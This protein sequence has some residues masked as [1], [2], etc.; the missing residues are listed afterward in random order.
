MCGMLTIDPGILLAQSGLM[1]IWNALW[2]YLL[3]FVG[4]SA[5]IFVHELG[6]FMVAKWMNVRVEK[7]AIGFFTELVGFTRGETRYSFNVLP[8]GG[9]VKMLGQ[10][11]FDDKTLELRTQGNPRS[12]VNKSVFQRMLIVSAGV[13]MNVLFAAFLFVIVFMHGVEENVTTIGQVLP[14]SPASLAGLQPGDTILK[15]DGKEIRQYQEIRFA[16][17]LADPHTPM[18]FEIERNGEIRTLTVKP[19]PEQQKNLLQVGIMPATTRDVV[20]ALDA[21]FEPDNPQHLHRGDVVVAIEGKPIDE[22]PK[23]GIEQLMRSPDGS[24]VTVTVERLVDRA[25]PDGPTTRDVQV[26]NRMY[27]DPSD[28]I[29]DPDTRNILGLIP[30]VEV[31]GLT[32]RGRARL[33]GLKEGDIILQWGPHWYPMQRQITE[34]VRDSARYPNAD[35]ARSWRQSMYQWFTW[36]PETDIPVKVARRGTA[37]H[38]WLTVTPK[39]RKKGARPMVGMTL[40]AVA[41]ETMRVAGVQERVHGMLTPAAEAGIPAGARILKLAETPVVSWPQLVELFRQAAGTSVPLTYETI[42]GREINCRFRVPHCLRTQLGL[43]TLSGIVSVDGRKFATITGRS[44]RAS[45]SAGHTLGLHEILRQILEDNAGEP[46][47]VTVRYQEVPFGPEFEKQTTISAEMI[48][49]WLGRIRYLPQLIMQLQIVTLKADGPIDALMIGLKK[50]SYFVLQVYTMMQRMIVS[51]TV[52]VEHMSGP[53]GIVKLGSDVARVGFVRLL[54]F[55][56][57]ISANLA[58]IN[59]LPLPIVDGG[60][61]VFLIIEK[62]KGSPVSIKVQV[63]TQVIGLFLIGAAFLFI[64]LQDVIRLAG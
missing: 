27:V 41:S 37:E 9:Y 44:R 26:F 10:E 5:V 42:H 36:N 11:D 54:F 35:R 29:G 49:P 14:E 39:I 38:I 2:P 13:V 17:L 47:Q 30:L 60:L 25:D 31:N 21:R 62:I 57:I 48:D 34:S 33:A 6:H 12:F 32:E 45:I 58:V 40:N 4:F 56:A 22:D 63:A 19:E 28:P 46:T 50:T 53:V 43:S 15:I 61:M 23:G 1:A 3:I 24:V 18:N 20:F 55:L 7:F 8:L 64:T 59:F 51:R 16:V 52:G